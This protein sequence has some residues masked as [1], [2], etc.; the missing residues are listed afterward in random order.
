[1][2]NEKAVKCVAHDNRPD[3]VLQGRHQSKGLHLTLLQEV[4]NRWN[5]RGS[6]MEQPRKEKWSPNK[7]GMFLVKVFK[8]NLV[9]FDRICVED[10]GFGSLSAADALAL[11]HDLIRI[12]FPTFFYVVLR[13]LCSHIHA[14]EGLYSLCPYQ[15][16]Y[17]LLL[18]RLGA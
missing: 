11:T 13:E 6:D 10:S 12:L 5:L 9:T 1:M 8:R 15:A 14:T 3:R 4:D 7:T 18:P 17:L 16:S 2:R